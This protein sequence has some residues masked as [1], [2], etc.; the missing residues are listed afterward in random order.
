LARQAKPPLW[1]VVLD[2]LDIALYASRIPK[3]SELLRT[4]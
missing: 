3:R 1:R 2:R 4:P